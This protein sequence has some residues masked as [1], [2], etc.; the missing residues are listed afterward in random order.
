MAI[1]LWPNADLESGIDDWT[2][3]TFAIVDH[4]S[5]RSWEQTYSMSID[6]DGYNYTGSPPMW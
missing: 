3:G 2:P 6:T 1:N 4:S 5:V